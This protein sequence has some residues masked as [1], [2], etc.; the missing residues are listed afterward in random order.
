MIEIN[1]T[2]FIQ[3]VNFLLIM[4]FLN[5]F[6]YRP[7]RDII[8]E[9]KAKYAGY[10]ADIGRFTRQ[11]EKRLKEI[12]DRLAEARREGFLKKDE[13]RGQGLDEEKRI[14]SSAAQDAEAEIGKLKEQIRGEILAARDVLKAEI[15]LFSRELAQKVL[16]RSLS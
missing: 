12:D 8:K 14:M 4:F 6:L 11:A 15:N 9:R 3:M 7:I 16:G 1:Y 5:R 13:I 10:E 2:L